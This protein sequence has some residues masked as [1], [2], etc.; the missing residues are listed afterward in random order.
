[1]K[2][3]RRSIQGKPKIK[4]LAGLTMRSG[5]QDLEAE[6]V[7]RPSPHPFSDACRRMLNRKVPHDPRHRTVLDLVVEAIFFKP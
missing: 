1:M 6:N 3:K 4:P 5:D 7:R 2:S